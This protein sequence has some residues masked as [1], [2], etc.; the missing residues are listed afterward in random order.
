MDESRVLV[1]DRLRRDM[2]L[3]AL[4]SRP[5]IAVE[6]GELDLV[7]SH[8]LLE[9]FL[10]P[11][12]EVLVQVGSG[13]RDILALN[14]GKANAGSARQRRMSVRGSDKGKT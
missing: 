5:E 11:S 4:G 13:H 9:E 8:P 14:A 1:F 10:T 6:T 3:R 12:L 2:S 7:D